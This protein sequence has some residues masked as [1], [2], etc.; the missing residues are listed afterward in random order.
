[1]LEDCELQ[2]NRQDRP[3][4]SYFLWFSATSPRVRSGDARRGRRVSH[5]SLTGKVAV[6]MRLAS[7]AEWIL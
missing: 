2:R 6:I 7:R 5:G 3:L 1:V 4:L